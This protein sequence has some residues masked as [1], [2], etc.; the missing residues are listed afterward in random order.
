MATEH[1]GQMQDFVTAELI[2]CSP[3]PE[4]LSVTVSEQPVASPVRDAM[5]ATLEQTGAGPP[6]DRAADSTLLFPL[7]IFVLNLLWSAR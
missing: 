3:E 5:E 4:V 6:P 1:A 7:F 2:D